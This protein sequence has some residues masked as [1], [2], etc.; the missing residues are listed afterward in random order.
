MM[1]SGIWMQSIGISP[2]SSAKLLTYLILLLN[3]ELEKKKR[4]KISVTPPSLRL[5][6]LLENP[7]HLAPSSLWPCVVQ[8][9]T[10]VSSLPLCGTEALPWVQYSDNTGPQIT[11]APAYTVLHQKRQS[12]EHS[13]LLVTFMIENSYF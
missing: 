1:L 12:R 5:V 6:P 9:R 3:L 8:L 7:S 10:G 2:L 13:M 4:R 11:A